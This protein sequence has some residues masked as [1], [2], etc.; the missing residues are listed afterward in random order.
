ME[1]AQELYDGM[2]RE[3][4]RRTVIAGK[5]GEGWK[6][7]PPIIDPDREAKMQALIDDELRR[8]TAAN[9]IR[10]IVADIRDERNTRAGVLN[11]SE[12]DALE[13]AASVCER[14][15]EVR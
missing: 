10:D 6:Q 4:A 7:D 12:L 2:R 11:D 13:F 14:H 9:I 8:E 3:Q 5:T 1:T 15:G